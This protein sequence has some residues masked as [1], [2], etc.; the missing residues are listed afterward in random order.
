MRQLQASCNPWQ[1]SN[2]RYTYRSCI[3]VPPDSDSESWVHPWKHWNKASRLAAN[4]TLLLET[5]RHAESGNL[6][7]R[8]GYNLGSKDIV[9][10]PRMAGH[11]RLGG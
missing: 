10:A 4:G 9:E 2:E 8:P 11:L 1:A 5:A 7:K 6:L 3:E